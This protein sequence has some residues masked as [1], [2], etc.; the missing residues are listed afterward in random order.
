MRPLVVAATSVQACIQGDQQGAPV[1]LEANALD[2]IRLFQA[3]SWIRYAGA[4]A[5]TG[6]STIV[7]I[8]A[9]REVAIPNLSLIFVLPVRLLKTAHVPS[10][11]CSSQSSRSNDPS[12]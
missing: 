9:D 1:M 8:A 11:L 12:P 5:L 3:P 7:A 10:R 6:L 4:L 2:A